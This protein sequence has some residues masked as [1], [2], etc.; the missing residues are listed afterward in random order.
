MHFEFDQVHA[1]VFGQVLGQVHPRVAFVDGPFE[2]TDE[3]WNTANHRPSW[4]GRGDGGRKGYFGDEAEPETERRCM[5][6]SSFPPA[7]AFHDNRTLHV[8]PHR[9]YDHCSWPLQDPPGRLDATGT[10]QM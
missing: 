9:R 3:A 2:A 7:A 1:G 10:L 4:M 8:K 6:V 5:G